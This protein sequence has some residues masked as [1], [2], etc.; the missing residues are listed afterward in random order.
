MKT[1]P[2]IFGNEL[3]PEQQAQEDRCYEAAKLL[4]KH[5]FDA[6][7]TKYIVTGPKDA[8]AGINVN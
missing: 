8:A 7:A 4:R 6:E 3:T 2:R 5:G 1:Q